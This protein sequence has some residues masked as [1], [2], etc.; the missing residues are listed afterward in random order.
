MRKKFGKLQIKDVNFAVFDI[1]TYKWIYPYAVGF[2]DGIEYKQFLGKNCIK[3]FISFIAV[4]K[5]RGYRIYAHNGGKFDFNFLVQELQHRKFN[6]NMIFQGSRCLLLKLYTHLYRNEEGNI[7]HSNV[8]QF[9]DSIGLL[10][11]GL[12]ALTKDFDV[13]HKKLNFMDKKGTERDYE[14]LYRLFKENDVRFH[15]YLRND[16]YGLYEV[17]V[18]FN[19][20]IKEN[21]G[22]LG[23]T[24]ASTSLKTFQTGY[25]NNDIKMTNKES[26]DEMKLS[27]FGGRVEILRMMLPEDKYRCYD[28]NSLYPYVMFNNEFPISKPKTINNITPTMIKELTGITK[29]RVKAPKDLYLPVLPYK[30]KLG[31][32][33]KLI[34]PL[35]KFDGYWDNVQLAKAMELGYKIEPTKMMVFKTDYIFKDYVTNFY[36]LKSS[37]EPKTP[38]YILA[39]LMLNCWD[40]KTEVLTPN[41][42]K[43]YD[44]INKGDKIYQFNKD[45][46]KLTETTV[47]D[48]IIKCSNEIYH[49][50][51][52]HID[53]KVTPNHRVLFKKYKTNSKF[54]VTKMKDLPDT[55]IKFKTSG[56]L[57]NESNG[58]D[59]SD[60]LIEIIAWIITEGNYQYT[61]N[62]NFTMIN[63]RQS[64]RVNL[65]NYLEIKKL[66]NNENIKFNEI[67]DGCERFYINSKSSKFLK[68]LLPNKY[69]IPD[70]VFELN[71]KQK[72]L[73]IDTLIKGDGTE[74]NGKIAYTQKWEKQ[75]DDLQHLCSICGYST[76]KS[77]SNNCYV[78][79]IRKNDYS[80][81]NSFY[82]NYKKE[83]IIKKQEGKIKVWGVNVN[84]GFVII[85][86][87]GKVVISGQSLYGKF[88]QNQESEMLV[89]IDNPKDLM[90]MDV[91][92][93]VDADHNLFKVK[94]ESKGNFF[95]P[96]ISIHVT[97][98]SQLR[99]YKFIEDLLS[100]GKIVSYLDT[101]SLFTNGHLPTSNKLG[102]MKR[103]YKFVSG[104][105]LLPKTYCIVKPDGSIKVKA[106]G[107]MMDFQNQLSEKSFQKALFK[108]DYSDFKIESDIETF[109]SMKTSFVRHHNFVS[110]DF[111]KKSI[112]ARYDKRKILKDYNTTPLII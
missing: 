54:L 104:Y 25:L 57:N 10:K 28:V 62:N 5:Y 30:L 82:N 17:L 41:G 35:G 83:S 77:K 16:V 108:K 15:D 100:K 112:H 7:T 51:T 33:N 60:N 38:S 79:Y 26:N 109:N 22:Q 61:K 3:D 63:I 24:I 39:K 55:Y 4:K 9:V 37:S 110:T 72:R 92:G 84:S 111:R 52:P 32:H 56:I 73:F 66:L 49:L 1:E 87:N 97:A 106:K 93:V 90:E 40:L 13:Q 29:C 96:Q 102:D 31:G 20:L 107:F 80:G 59:I 43:K 86:R 14:Y 85:R 42:W 105:F 36:K 98:L 76:V 71:L 91:V 6:I 18:K 50:H 8:I 81:I 88:A 34:F 23:L 74:S 70:W 65:E 11:F 103:E 99:L 58:I 46:G 75:I 45:I 67:F 27:Y 48:K 12:D 47:N 95:I 64:K 2:Y 53:F 21:N 68:I 69:N 89:K 44:E 101:D 19:N 94:S 78:L